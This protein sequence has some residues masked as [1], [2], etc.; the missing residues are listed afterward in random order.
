MSKQLSGSRMLAEE[1][2]ILSE[3]STE[4]TGQRYPLTQ[5]Q[6]GIWYMEK[7]FPDT[8][9]GV[10]AATLRVQGAIN[11]DQ[12]ESAMNSF[13]EKNE[14]IRFRITEE[15]GKPV[16][17]IAP[18]EPMR[19]DRYEFSSNEELYK[20]DETQSALPFQIIDAPL[21]SFALIRIGENDGGFYMR[22]HHL[23]SDAWTMSLLVNQFFEYYATLQAGRSVDPSLL[24]S[25]TTYIDSQNKYLASK[26]FEI[27]KCYWEEKFKD[28]QEICTLKNRKKSGISSL[29]RRRTLVL[30]QKLSTKIHEYCQG[31]KVSEFSLF[32]AAVSMYLNRVAGKE[33]VILGTTLLNRTNVAEKNTAGMFASLGVPLC[34][35]IRYD[36]NF[37]NLF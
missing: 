37:D 8:S 9:I 24:P 15:N 31:K 21:F 35:P 5:Q 14:A 1:N 16:Q 22:F 10:I 23:I 13:V 20:W 12:I 32:I 3:K 17:Y 30:P 19:F 25:Y 2:E 6:K 33:N 4:S 7:L 11:I 34:I 27:D 26:R 36:M 28:K 29:A 18:Y